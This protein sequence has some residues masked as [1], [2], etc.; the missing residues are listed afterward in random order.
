[1]CAIAQLFPESF[2][3]T[4]LVFLSSGHYRPKMLTL[5]KEAMDSDIATSYDKYGGWNYVQGRLHTN[6]DVLTRSFES[7][8]RVCSALNLETFTL[9]RTNL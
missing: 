5:V 2:I 8:A 4:Y 7:I 1:M 9:E 6:K 3:F